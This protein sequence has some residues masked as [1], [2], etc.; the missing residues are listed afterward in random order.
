MTFAL[1]FLNLCLS[2]KSG[3]FLQKAPFAEKIIKQLI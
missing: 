2:M 3:L 1:K